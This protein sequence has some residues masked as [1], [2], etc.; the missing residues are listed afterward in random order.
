MAM[1]KL[2]VKVQETEKQENSTLGQIPRDRR[3]RKS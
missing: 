2:E 1:L 3:G